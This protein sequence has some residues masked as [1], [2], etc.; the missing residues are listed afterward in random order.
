MAATLLDLL[1][2]AIHV[3]IL[4]LRLANLQVNV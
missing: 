1:C 3:E 4:E 2:V